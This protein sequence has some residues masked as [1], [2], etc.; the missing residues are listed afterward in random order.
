MRRVAVLLLVLLG[1]IATVPLSTAATPASMEAATAP[2]DPDRDVIGW[3]NG[4]WYNE[5]IPVDQTGPEDDGLTE[6]E[7]ELLLARTMARVEYLRDAEFTRPVSVRFV[8][9]DRFKERLSEMSFGVVKNDQVYEAMFVYG[10]DENPPEQLSGYLGE[11]V[12]GYAAEEGA[13]NITIVTRDESVQAVDS[14]VLAHE[15]VHVLQDQ[16]FDLSQERYQRDTLDGEWA[17]DGLIEGEASYVDSQY[18]ER[19]AGQW[20]CVDAPSDW[21]GAHVPS[22]PG[23]DVLSRQPYEDGATYVNTIQRGDGWAAVDRAHH[24]PPRTS[25]QIIHADPEAQPVP[26]GGGEYSTAAWERYHTDTLGEVG[27][28]TMFVAYDRRVPREDEVYQEGLYERRHPWDTLDSERTPSSGWGNDRLVAYRQGDQRGYV[29][30][31]VWD[32]RRDAG[33]FAEAYEQ[34]LDGMGAEAVGDGVYVVPAGPFADAF[35]LMRENRTVRIVNAPTVNDLR[36]IDTRVDLGSVSD[37][38]MTRPTVD[39][40]GS[41]TGSGLSETTTTVDDSSSSTSSGDPDQR[42]DETDANH[43]DVRTP[44]TPGLLTVAVLLVALG[45]LAAVRRG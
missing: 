33:E 35:C 28:F 36:E 24:D 31:T 21:S 19:C 32:S 17:V 39:D 42:S 16:R 29:W 15:L 1:T 26:M 14:G 27:I 5:S 7:T 13:E 8:G 23:F 45:T 25:E 6:R 20:S 40:R 37:H 22:D 43:T 12:L 44:M 10:E 3:E 30:T 2:P 18:A 41:N 9:R 11:A 4:V 34:V 38:D